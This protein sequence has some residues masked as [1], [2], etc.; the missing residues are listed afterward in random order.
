MYVDDTDLLHLAE[1]KDV[2]DEE[3]TE[4]VQRDAKVWGELEQSTDGILKATKCSLFLLIYNWIHGRVR[5]K[6]L[7]NLLYAHH[8]VI[9]ETPEGEE[10]KVYPLHVNVPQPTVLTFQ[11]KHMS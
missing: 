3:L 8:E 9:V 10:D 7:N 6:T 1:S 5:L 2:E 4:S 11:Y